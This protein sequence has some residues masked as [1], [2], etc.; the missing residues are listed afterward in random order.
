MPGQALVGPPPVAVGCERQVDDPRGLRVLAHPDLPLG[1]EHVRELLVER[2]QR[3]AGVAPQVPALPHVL[4]QRRDRPEQNQECRQRSG[5]HLG[6]TG[7]RPPTQDQPDEKDGQEQEG[8]RRA[9]LDE[10]KGQGGKH[11]AQQ[12]DGDKAKGGADAGC[13]VELKQ[14]GSD[15]DRK[16]DRQGE[17]VVGQAKRHGTKQDSRIG[18]SPDG[19]PVG[20]RGRL[21]RVLG[22]IVA[23]QDRMG[24]PRQD[25]GAQVSLEQYC[26]NACV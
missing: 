26:N 17:G 15:G 12:I 8:Q 21:R 14:H 9:Q 25:H 16:D 10:R 4:P 7:R 1:V 20:G 19:R 24:E 3:A 6:K 11:P 23:R 5:I 22:R 2:A 13:E 18:E